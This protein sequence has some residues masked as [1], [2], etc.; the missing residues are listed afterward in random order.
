LLNGETQKAIMG[1]VPRDRAGMA[2]GISTTSRF[3]G[4]LLGFAVLSFVL[5]TMTRRSLTGTCVGAAACEHMQR[6]A[7]AVVAGDLPRATAGI[8]PGAR[9]LA[10]EHARLAYSG[11][12]S[13][14]LLVAAVI[15]SVSAVLV[16]L[17][18]RGR[19]TGTSSRY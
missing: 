14:A 11:G 18:M 17:L 7:D 3:S 10:M 12:F 15:A 6:F 5:A 19:T 8:E 4:I 2:S 16:G 1:A 9:A 13:A